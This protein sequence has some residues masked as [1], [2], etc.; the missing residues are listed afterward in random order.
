M[1]S[2]A[3]LAFLALLQSA[4]PQR[5]QTADTPAVV[6]A[7]SSIVVPDTTAILLRAQLATMRE[8][9][10]RLL[11]TVHWSL[12]GIV[13]AALVLVTAGWFANFRI[14]ERDKAALQ[15]ELS[16]SVEARRV[17]LTQAI[18]TGLVEVRES[19]ESLVTA[20]SEKVKTEVSLDVK[21]LRQLVLR[22]QH[23]FACLGI[24]EWER[25]KV[26]A[27]V[28]SS[29]TAALNAAVDVGVHQFE[30]G[31]ILDRLMTTLKAGAAIDAGSAHDVT[32]VL[33]RLP[34]EFAPAKE[35]ILALLR[36]I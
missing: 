15:R 4:P 25:K 23:Q 31:T 36:R 29:C 35:K 12:A 18:A 20:R 2:L 28:V 33:D 13:A 34:K 32:K 21:R 14:Y 24:E 10:Q 30:L 27:N 26:P 19:L 22:H 17:E 1:L 3:S 8:L 5:L 16:E 9:A 6:A 11:D 7:P